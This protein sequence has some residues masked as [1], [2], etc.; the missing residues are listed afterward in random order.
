MTTRMAASHKGDTR[1]NE[2]FSRRTNGN[3]GRRGPASRETRSLF[4]RSG[5]T[6]KCQTAGTGRGTASLSKAAHRLRWGKERGNCCLAMGDCPNLARWGRNPA[7]GLKPSRAG[8]RAD[9]PRL[10]RRMGGVVNPRPKDSGKHGSHPQRAAKKKY[11][12][13]GSVHNPHK[14]P[15]GRLLKLSKPPSAERRET[16]GSAG[17]PWAA[18][19]G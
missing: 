8:P 18:V 15:L 10:R 6:V 2:V 19:K 13:P 17:L 14:L 5:L 7:S 12:K 1:T 16:G 4:R 3:A 11:S 9:R